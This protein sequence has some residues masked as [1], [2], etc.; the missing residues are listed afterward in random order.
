[1]KFKAAIVIAALMI[2]SMGI[3]IP[4]TTVTAYTKATV[5]ITQT[6]VRD[7]AAVLITIT[8]T[9]PSDGENVEN[10]LIKD[11]TNGVTSWFTTPYGGNENVI[12][13]WDNIA[14]NLIQIGD[15]IVRV[16]DNI[17]NAVSFI[18]AAG[19]ALVSAGAGENAAGQ[20]MRVSSH[21]NLRVLATILYLGQRT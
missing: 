21:E 5:S 3:L 19:Q 15:N 8:I 18:K 9:N 12:E 7:N 16:R 17:L 20:Y 11:V 13:N 4:T 1:V 10:I 6:V 2:A 14:D